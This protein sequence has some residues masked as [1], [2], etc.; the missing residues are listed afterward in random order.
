MSKS[1]LATKNALATIPVKNLAKAKAFYERTLGLEPVEGEE[2][3]VQG[4]RAGSSMIIVYESSFAGTNQATAVTWPV[5][6]DLDTIVADLK[7][8][9]VAFEHYDMPNT[10]LE[11]DIHVAGRM[12]VAWFKDPDGN[13]INVGNY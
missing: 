5:G 3:G 10:K 13:I 1:K 12:R 8:K 9:G 6:D 11:G 7:A 2:S 4:Y